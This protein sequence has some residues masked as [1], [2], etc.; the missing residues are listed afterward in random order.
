MKRMLVIACLAVA[1][2]ALAQTPGGLSLTIDEAVKLGL[3]NAPAVAAAKAQEAAA[4]SSVTALRAL[5]FPTV[6]LQSEYMRLNNVTEFQIPDGQGGSRV[7]YPNIPNLYRNRIEFQAPIYSFGRV[8]SNVAAANSTVIA[9]TADRQVAESDIQL[10]VI[11]AYW[12]LAT[13]R[14]SEKVL[15]ESLARTD[16]WVGDVQARVDAGVLPPS[17]VQSAQ[18]QR[19]RQQVRLLQARNEA[20]LAQLDLARLIGAQAGSGIQ[21]TTPV[22]Q[23]PTKV[24]EV[25]SISPDEL[26][27]RALRQR[28]ERA[29]LV[30]RG[31]GLRQ[32]AK[33][34]RANL[35]PYII[36][37]G[38]FEAAK[39]NT[40]FVPPVNEWRDSWTLD[41]KFNW[42][43]FDSGRTRAQ[44]AAFTAQANAVDFRRTELDGYVSL[45]IRQRLLDLQF[46]KEAIAASEQA[47][48]AA[49][50]ARRVLDER[51]RAG[52]ATSTEVLDAQVALLEAQL[53]RTRL[54][55][56]LRLSEA[57]LLHA[58]GE[59]Y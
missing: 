24:S 37:Q 6:N 19:A 27:E 14:E 59:K 2:P 36:S 7:L 3:Q 53:E 29:G 50:E 41:I 17:D 15:V 48:S 43:L 33:A 57:R 55:A 38:W 4:Q 28:G 20:S 23:I 12:M 46:G 11:R 42:P 44:A 56:G 47:I 22:E 25:A 40:R 58:L 13:A 1:T 52:V 16:A 30:A 34:T 8:A 45:E 10:D 21:L 39:P 31:E 49:A 5:A 18:A 51:F 35:K 54:T 9:A 32:Q 26:I